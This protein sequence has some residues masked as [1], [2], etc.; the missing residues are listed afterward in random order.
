[1]S[2]WTRRSHSLARRTVKS[3][4]PRTNGL[5]AIIVLSGVGYLSVSTIKGCVDMT[6]YG[7]EYQSKI[8]LNKEV[9]E[10]P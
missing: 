2:G 9:N 6:F 4:P 10:L 5:I 1:M 7:P 8:I 3:K